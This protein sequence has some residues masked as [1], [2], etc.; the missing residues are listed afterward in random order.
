M[1][2]K[3]RVLA[4]SI[5]YSN[6]FTRAITRR[7]ALDERCLA[8]LLVHD[9]FLLRLKTVPAVRQHFEKLVNAT[10]PR[11]APYFKA[12]SK[13][14]PDPS[15]STSTSPKAPT[16]TT[17]H[18]I[19]TT[20]RHPFSMTCHALYLHDTDEGL[21]A[22][23]LNSV[24]SDTCVTLL[25]DEAL[26]DE[27]KSLSDKFRQVKSIIRVPSEVISGG[28]NE[29]FA[30]RISAVKSLDSVIIPIAT[31]GPDQTEENQGEP[32]IASSYSLLNGLWNCGFRNFSISNSQGDWRFQIP[33]LAETFEHLD[34]K[35]KRGYTPELEGNIP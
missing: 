24:T 26:L 16:E 5:L 28:K 31:H 17:Q 35:L 9:I 1:L 34:I 14:V 7:I 8:D 15:E 20:A 22:Q 12:A 4:V 27:A 25:S 3:F 11:T 6:R 32:D 23:W 2:R 29:A 33:Q 30:L 18:Q 13:S 10:R 21:T 19:S